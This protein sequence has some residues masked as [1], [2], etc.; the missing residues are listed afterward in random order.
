MDKNRKKELKELYKQMK[1]DMGVFIIRC[2]VS[3]KCHLQ[4]TPDLRG[5]MNGAQVR[6]ASGSHPFR[7]LQQ[8][9]KKYGPESFVMEVLERLEVDEDEEKTDYSDDL[10]LLRLIWEERLAGEGWAFYKKR[11]S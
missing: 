2:N 10:E 3:S 8:E 7:E 9:W 5:V 1:P 11:E 6:L 4:A